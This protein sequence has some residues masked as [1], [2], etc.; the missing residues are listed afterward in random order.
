VRQQKREL[1]SLNES[2]SDS[3]RTCPDQNPHLEGEELQ[4]ALAKLRP[5]QREALILVGAEGLSYEDAATVCS[6][7]IGTIKSRVNRA[8]RRLAGL[9]GIDNRAEIGPDDRTK[10]AL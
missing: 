5:E 2:H 8:R 1:Q 6:V 3:L 7:P 10:A 4:A 9:L